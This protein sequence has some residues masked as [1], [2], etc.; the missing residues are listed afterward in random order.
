[1]TAYCNTNPANNQVT[2]IINGATETLSLAGNSTVWTLHQ[3]GIN[4]TAGFIFYLNNYR[5]I[6]GVT[7]AVQDANPLSLRGSPVT[8]Y[9]LVRAAK[10][11]TDASISRGGNFLTSLGNFNGSQ[12]KVWRLLEIV[13]PSPAT[14]AYAVNSGRFRKTSADEKL[15]L[16]YIF[17]SYSNVAGSIWTTYFYIH[18]ADGSYTGFF[19]TNENQ[20][21]GA[22]NTQRLYSSGVCVLPDQLPPG[23]YYIRFANAA[24]LTMDTNDRLR[25]YLQQ[26]VS[27]A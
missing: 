7:S 6:K 17:S 15:L 26:G 19:D 1:V 25:L 23:N 18:R 4:T 9:A 24:Q 3:L 2:L 27:G 16:H 20:W 11:F 13:G 10:T 8:N 21:Y 14:A 12:L 22:A 5:L